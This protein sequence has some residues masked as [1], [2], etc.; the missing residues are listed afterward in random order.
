[1]CVAVFGSKLHN[2]VG[3]VCCITCTYVICG[4][5]M[6]VIHIIQYCT[7]NILCNTYSAYS[8]VHVIKTVCML[9]STYVHASTYVI[10]YM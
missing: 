1:M 3:H 9:C 7:C 10:Q 2:T 5:Y 6:Y 4:N 8:T